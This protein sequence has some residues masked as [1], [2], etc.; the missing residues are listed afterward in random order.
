VAL[1]NVA[2][3]GV[4]RAGVTSV[5]ELLRTTEPVPVD[6]VVP[7][8][9]EVT[10]RAEPSVRE[11]RCWMPSTTLVPSLYTTMDLLCGT[12]MPVPV[13]FFTVMVSPPVVPFLM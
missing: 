5:G 13:V 9:P 2:D 6:V 12:A 1:V 8:P 3:E 10:G 11:V 7:V 4:P